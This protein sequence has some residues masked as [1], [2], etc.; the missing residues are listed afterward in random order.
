MR[1]FEIEWLAFVKKQYPEVAHNIATAKTISP[2]DDKRL[3]EA[4][5]AFKTQFKA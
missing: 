4:C 3:H 2:D 1:K 5:K